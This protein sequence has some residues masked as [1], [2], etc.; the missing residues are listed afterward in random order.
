MGCGLLLTALALGL[1]SVPVV[2]DARRQ[3]Q[4]GGTPGICIETLAI[5]GYDF[6]DDQDQGSLQAKD[7]SSI[8]SSNEADY[9]RIR[10]LLGRGEYEFYFSAPSLLPGGTA[11]SMTVEFSALVEMGSGS[12]WVVDI[13]ERDPSTSNTWETIGDLSSAG[14]DWSTVALTL[15]SSD[16]TKYLDPSSN[17]ELLVRVYS[18]SLLQDRLPL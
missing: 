13:F 10:S 6:Q 5:S 11:T 7:G 16:L 18:T 2:A 9:V 8:S 17:N 15:T 4:D 12:N 3:L 14:G 1:A